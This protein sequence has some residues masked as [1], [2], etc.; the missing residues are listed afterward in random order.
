M[1]LF[2]AVVVFFWGGGVSKESLKKNTTDHPT[3]LL[4]LFIVGVP[5]HHSTAPRT[6]ARTHLHRLLIWW[7]MAA[8]ESI[9][10][11]SIA[12]PAMHVVSGLDTDWLGVDGWGGTHEL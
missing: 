2:V 9:A 8:H 1:L 7:P 3:S 11:V 12:Q 10:A 5:V 6:D 4:L